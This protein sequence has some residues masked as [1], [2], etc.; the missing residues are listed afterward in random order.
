MKVRPWLNQEYTADRWTTKGLGHR[1]PAPLKIGVEFWLS[2]SWTENSPLIES[3]TKNI[4]SIND[5]WY[6]YYNLYSYNQLSK[7]NVLKI[8][9]KIQNTFTCTV[10]YLLG[11]KNPQRHQPALIETRVVRGPTAW[12]RAP[13]TGGHPPVPAW[14][15]IWERDAGVCDTPPRP[16]ASS[17][18]SLDSAWSLPVHRKERG[19]WHVQHLTTSCCELLIHF[20]DFNKCRRTIVMKSTISY[21]RPRLK[22]PKRGLCFYSLVK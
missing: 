20:N 14:I 8:L 5:I 6:V 7:D 12:G 11:K 17:L 4:R 1:P 2:Q 13:G 15:F 22:I 19:H 10:L 21:Y 9:R 18:G 16:A 3:L